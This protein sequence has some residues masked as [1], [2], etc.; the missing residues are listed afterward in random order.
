MEAVPQLPPDRRLPRATPADAGRWARGAVPQCLRQYP[1]Q[2]RKLAQVDRCRCHTDAVS[3][4]AQ[5]HLALHRVPG[6]PQGR[7]STSG[8]RNVEAVG[9]R[10]HDIEYGPD[11]SRCRGAELPDP[12]A[13]GRHAGAEA[14][15]LEPKRRPTVAA[16]DD[17][18]VPTHSVRAALDRRI[19]IEVGVGSR[20][21]AH[22]Q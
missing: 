22:P 11:R 2:R 6:D 4:V 19:V 5:D 10:T 18:R 7:A 15:W 20:I 17:R 1:D 9:E 21:G 3:P 12:P 8:I 16:K 14:R 13:H